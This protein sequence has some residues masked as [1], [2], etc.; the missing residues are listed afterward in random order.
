MISVFT[1]L[2]LDLSDAK[3]DATVPISV[4]VF[5]V[6]LFIQQERKGHFTPK[7]MQ[8]IPLLISGGLG[9]LSRLIELDVLIN[10][11]NMQPYFIYS[12]QLSV[13]VAML[14]SVSQ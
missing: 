13:S 5:E 9:T 4:F 14:V 1:V 6:S 10:A 7:N 11:L 12:I 8:K 2:V 3:T